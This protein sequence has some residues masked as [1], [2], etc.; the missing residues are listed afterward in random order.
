MEKIKN[1]IITGA[2][3]GIG[4]TIGKILKEKGVKVF[5]IS[6][7]NCEE[8]ETY[9]CDVSNFDNVKK[10][11][12]EI[13]VKCNKIDALINCAGYG[14]SGAVELTREEDAQKIMDVNFLGSFY[15]IKYAL[16][17]MTRG[18]KIINISS[19]CALYPV[20]FRAFYCASKSAL[21]MLSYGLKMELKG[22]GID[23]CCVCPGEVQTNFSKNRQK[24]LE[25]NDKYGDAVVSAAKH[26]AN[27]KKRMS[28][29]VVANRV[30]KLLEKKHMKPFII[31]SAKYKVLNFVTRFVPTSVVLKGSNKILGGKR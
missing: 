30:I 23:V 2:S 4:L 20:P 3:S 21:Q 25:T 13:G 5:N 8:F 15:T 18:A 22:A 17:Y 14:I 16:K 24:N 11:I 29:M 28:P 9:T 7:E 10:I 27:E 31:V 19:A 12:D 26:I 1:V 6:R